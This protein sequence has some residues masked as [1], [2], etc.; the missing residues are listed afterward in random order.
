M[1]QTDQILDSMENSI[2]AVTNY[3]FLNLD[4]NAMGSSPKHYL[5]LQGYQSAL[6]GDPE[7]L[8]KY[9]AA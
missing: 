5:T 9:I 1:I 4:T 6:L 7:S 2:N 3:Q 8:G